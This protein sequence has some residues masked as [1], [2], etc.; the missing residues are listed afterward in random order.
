[1]NLVERRLMRWPTTTEAAGAFSW[2]RGD[3][4]GAGCAASFIAAAILAF[5]YRAWG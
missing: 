2:S 3:A 1:M 4:P 5:P